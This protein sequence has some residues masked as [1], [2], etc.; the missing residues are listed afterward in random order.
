MSELQ[1]SLAELQTPKDASPAGPHVQLSSLDEKVEK[2]A[3]EAELERLRIQLRVMS[4]AATPRTRGTPRVQ[5]RARIDLAQERAADEHKLR[6]HAERRAEAAGSTCGAEGVK[7]LAQSNG[8]ASPR[9]RAFCLTIALTEALQERN[10]LLQTQ[11]QKVSY[12][13]T[14]QTAGG[15]VRRK[16]PSFDAASPTTA[17]TARLADGAVPSSDYANAEYTSGKSKAVTADTLREKELQASTVAGTS[18]INHDCLRHLMTLT[19]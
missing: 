11:I 5:L 7:Y 15:K 8:A 12:S 13:P 19:F 16:K 4:T 14:S 17:S 6:L 1:A 2:A 10:V 3:L 9:I 18:S